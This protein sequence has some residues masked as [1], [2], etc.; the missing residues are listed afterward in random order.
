MHSTTKQDAMQT[1]SQHVL[2]PLRGLDRETVGDDIELGQKHLGLWRASQ[3]RQHNS[4]RICSLGN[5]HCSDAPWCA[6]RKKG[7]GYVGGY[8]CWISRL[9]SHLM[10]AKYKPPIS[11]MPATP[12]APSSLHRP[13]QKLRKRRL[14]RGSQTFPQL[15]Y[16]LVLLVHVLVLLAQLLVLLA[17]VLVLLAQL[18][19]DYARLS[20]SLALMAGQTA[21]QLTQFLVHFIQLLLQFQFIRLPSSLLLSLGLRLVTS[22][23]EVVGCQLLVAS[24]LEPLGDGR[25]GNADG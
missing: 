25:E 2:L 15:L 14:R 16:L 3:T 10:Q 8:V 18:S 1:A 6:P 4:G 19:V 22:M 24:L 11:S 5:H 21:P 7:S 20:C 13:D 12:S 23:S 17:H 9:S